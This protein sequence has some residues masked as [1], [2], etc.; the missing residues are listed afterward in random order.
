MVCEGTR[1][2]LQQALEIEVA[3]YIEANAG[4]RDEKGHRLVVRNGTMPERNILTGMGPIWIRQ[5]R[6]DDTKLRGEEETERFS[7]RILPRYL[8][9][10]SSVDNL[11][12]VLYLKGVSS[13]QFVRALES[14]L[15]EGPKGLS[16]TNIVRLKA[17]WEQEYQG[18]A[19]W[20]FSGKKYVYIWADGVYFNVRL[21]EERSYVLVI[22]GCNL[23]RK[24]ELLVLSDGYRERELSWLEMLRDRKVWGLT[25][26][27]KLAIR[28]GALGFWAALGKDFPRRNGSDAGC[29][30]PRMYWTSC[31]KGCRV[32]PSR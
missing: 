11:L 8:R 25:A 10:V 28:D 15:K 5:P 2:V 6:L 29:T 7:S 9:R 19:T 20:D 4:N 30:R 22:M 27:P 31:P 12:P 21:E 32:K 17:H 23:K 16:A 13:K 24:K 14:I 26:A 1:K 3:E 18:W